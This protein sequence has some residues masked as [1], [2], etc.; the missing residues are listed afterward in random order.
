M[1][2]QQ[3]REVTREGHAV[4]LIGPTVRMQVW[5]DGKLYAKNVRGYRAAK[6]IFDS[7]IA[8]HAEAQ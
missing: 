3:P 5:I 2:K 7:Y 1:A 6:R 8:R 4:S